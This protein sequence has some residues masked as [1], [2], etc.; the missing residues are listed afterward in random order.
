ME[1]RYPYPVVGVLVINPEDEILL[2][3]F[4]DKDSSYGIPGGKVEW[5]ETI[6]DA[7][8]REVKEEVGLN[9]KFDNLL[10]VQEALFSN[11]IPGREGKHFIFLECVCRTDSSEVKLDG[12]EISNYLWMEPKKALK[13]NLNSFTRRFIEKYLETS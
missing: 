3:K 11:E 2:V 1:E 9:V 5:G 10:F 13:L 6:Q 8:K 7:A 12:K 4:D